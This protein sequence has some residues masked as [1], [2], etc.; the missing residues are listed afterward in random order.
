M[1]KPRT[2]STELANRKTEH[3]LYKRFEMLAI[4]QFKWSGLPE[5]I[6]ERHIERVL[7]NE[8]KVLFFEDAELGLLCLPAME[9]QG[10]NVYG[11]PLRYSATGF[12]QAFLDIPR[13]KCVLIE[14]NKLRM[15]TALAVAYFVDQLYEVVRTRDVNIQT[16]KAPFFVVTDDKSVLTFKKILEEIAKNNVAV[17]GD[18]SYNIEEAIKV[19]QTGVK[20]LTAELTDTYHDIMNEA[21]TYLGINNANTDKKER[22]ITS[23]ADSNNQFIDSCA[24]MFLEA[25]QRA[26]EEINKKFGLSLSVEL[27]CPR[28]QEGEANVEIKQQDK[29][30]NT[31][32]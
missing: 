10:V 23:E 26:C 20:P 2:T 32:Q 19:F 15:P 29:A 31:S 22:L 17:F 24:Q 7:F 8:G 18:K 12:N 3:F 16:L 11:D 28:A 4:N 1:T 6:E 30:D 25:R 27:R 5:T 14:N 13:D 9:G 21:L